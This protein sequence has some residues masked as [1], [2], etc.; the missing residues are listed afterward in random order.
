MPPLE[1]AFRRAA[2]TA[3]LW[4]AAGRC[5]WS[6]PCSDALG[7]SAVNGLEGA[8]SICS[9]TPAGGDLPKWVLGSYASLTLSPSTALSP[10]EGSSAG[11]LAWTSNQNFVNLTL[12]AADFSGVTG[13]WSAYSYLSLAYASTS[14]TARNYKTVFNLSASGSGRTYRTDFANLTRPS[15]SAGDWDHYALSLNYVRNL[16]GDSLGAVD[17]LE[18]QQAAP[19]VYF[20]QS[21]IYLD[22]LALSSGLPTGAPAPPPSPVEASKIFCNDN[23]PCGTPLTITWTATVGS[24]YGYHIYR[25]PSGLPGTFVSLTYV[26]GAGNT[27]FV[28]ADAL[29]FTQSYII[30]PFITFTAMTSGNSAY[31]LYCDQD[32]ANPLVGVDEWPLSA[33]TA[34]SFNPLRNCPTFTP[35]PTISP[36]FTPSP[37]DSPTVSPTRTASPTP[38]PTGTPTVSPTN[39]RF[40]VN[41]EEPAL[42][43]PN[44]FL[45]ESQVL[46]FGNV[47]AGARVRIY[48]VIGEFVIEKVFGG[49]PAVDTWDGTNA[50]GVKVVS[51]VYFA[52]IQGRVYRFVLIRK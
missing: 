37:P 24:F 10:A 43:Y 45:A 39:T 35:S 6:A 25:S 41:L 20:G 32:P 22:N 23:K 29:S 14:T 16:S 27:S 52:A 46:H 5:G 31:F 42:V 13:D 28:D 8:A 47:P 49:D 2:L 4:A 18:L 1:S 9:Y 17:Y 21:S 44:P 50:N 12:T 15:Y 26:A 51:G 7:Y 34:A 11:R 48:N 19:P 40:V 3:A 36:T 38:L 33:A 30:L